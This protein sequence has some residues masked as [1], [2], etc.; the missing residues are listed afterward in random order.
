METPAET[1]RPARTGAPSQSVR[2]RCVPAIGLSR[3]ATA[4]VAAVTE[5]GIEAFRAVTRRR[6]F[7]FGYH[8][9]ELARQRQRQELP[10]FPAR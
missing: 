10:S 8:V 5:S 6:G 3:A 1:C 2:E 7:R 9:A 4:V